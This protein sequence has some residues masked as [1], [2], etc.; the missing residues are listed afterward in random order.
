MKDIDVTIRWGLPGICMSRT[1]VILITI[2][3][4]KTFAASDEKVAFSIARRVLRREMPRARI[5]NMSAKVVSGIL[6]T[7]DALKS[8]ARLL[9]CIR[10]V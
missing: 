5:M 7:N 4:G 3:G 1:S 8:P 6:E 9:Y 2:V 10:C